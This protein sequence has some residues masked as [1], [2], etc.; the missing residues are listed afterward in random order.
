[1]VRLSFGSG[2]P[3]DTGMEPD[4]AFYV[5][6]RADAY[7]AAL[8]EGEAAAAFLEYT[9]PDLVVEVEVTNADRGKAERYA[10]MG[11]RELRQLHGRG[12]PQNLWVEA[13]E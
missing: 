7:S 13:K 3:P 2:D 4:C 9:A 6:E 12:L 1:M 8:R 10:D 11:V 5:G